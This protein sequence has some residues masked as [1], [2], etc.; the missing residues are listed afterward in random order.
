MSNTLM[1]QIAEL[2][3]RIAAGMASA[4][5]LRVVVQQCRQERTS[6]LQRREIVKEQA[7]APDGAALLAQLMGTSNDA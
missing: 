5:D 1:E 4:E 3:S 7:K 2:R 6:A